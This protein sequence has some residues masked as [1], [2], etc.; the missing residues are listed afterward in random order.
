MA[1]TYI[2]ILIL[3]DYIYDYIY[4]NDIISLKYASTEY[5]C[6][7]HTNTHTQTHTTHSHT[8]IYRQHIHIDLLYV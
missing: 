3:Y 6:F 4:D 5:I 2:A 8:H 1:R 7:Y